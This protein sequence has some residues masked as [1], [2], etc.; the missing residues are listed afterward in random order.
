MDFITQTRALLHQ[1]IR[2][3]ELVGAFYRACA[4]QLPEEQELW[5]TLDSEEQAHA[6]LLRT[7]LPFIE[8]GQV[9]LNPAA[10]HPE[11]LSAF[12]RYV[13]EQTRFVEMGDLP[14][15]MVLAIALD[16]EQTLLEEDALKYFNGAAPALDQTREHLRVETRRHLAR[17]QAMKNGLR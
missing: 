1:L 7:L 8:Q 17:I 12:T 6:D 5:T 10:I 2:H 4:R 13:Q 11:T 15:A 3:E 16:I 9:E 14:L